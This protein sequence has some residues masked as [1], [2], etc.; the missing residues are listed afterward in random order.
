VPSADATPAVDDAKTAA[1][2]A[3]KEA[4]IAAVKKQLDEAVRDAKRIKLK[5]ST[6]INPLQ[7]QRLA[8]AFTDAQT[9]ARAINAKLKELE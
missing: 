1:E 7:K 6:A 8:K 9:K 5:H 4:E 3:K 2:R